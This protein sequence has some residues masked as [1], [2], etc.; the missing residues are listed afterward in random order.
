MPMHSPL[1][2][3]RMAATSAFNSAMA[4]FDREYQTI[5]GG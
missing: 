4:F 1:P 5:P 2:A 3:A